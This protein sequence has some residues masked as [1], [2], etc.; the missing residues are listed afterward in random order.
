MRRIDAVRHNGQ[1]YDSNN[2]SNYGRAYLVDPSQP[3]ALHTRILCRTGT[4]TQAMARVAD[5]VDGQHTHTYTH[6]LTH[7]LNS[8]TH[9]G[10]NLSSTDCEMHT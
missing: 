9:T 4:G 10:E 1:N 3:T 7:S 8:L 2:P 5:V 6:T